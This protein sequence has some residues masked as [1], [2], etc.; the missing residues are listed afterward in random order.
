MSIT[1]LEMAQLFTAYLEYLTGDKVEDI[2]RKSRISNAKK[3]MMND[4][5][6]RAAEL[7]IA[8]DVLYAESSPRFDMTDELIEKGVFN[9]SEDIN[10]GLGAY[11]LLR[12]LGAA[13]RREREHPICRLRNLSPT[14][15]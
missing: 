7:M 8:L 14:K 11:Y 4:T 13:E 5:S 2:I 12:L 1:K 3:G 9:G 6:D 10:K 15:V